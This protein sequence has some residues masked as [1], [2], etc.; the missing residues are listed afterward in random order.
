M[1]PGV[2]SRAVNELDASGVVALARASM[3][4]TSVSPFVS[5]ALKPGS[6][7]DTDLAPEVMAFSSQLS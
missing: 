2:C 1:P 3:H 5:C 6:L 7:P 4:S